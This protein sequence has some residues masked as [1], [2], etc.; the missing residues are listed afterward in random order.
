MHTTRAPAAFHPEPPQAS[1]QAMQQQLHHLAAQLRA[2]WQPN[3]ALSPLARLQAQHARDLDAL[4]DQ[5]GDS[6]HIA[7]C[8]PS[9][10]RR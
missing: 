5:F 2:L 1:F 4:Q 10:P 8:H 9:A 7:A 6:M 3:P